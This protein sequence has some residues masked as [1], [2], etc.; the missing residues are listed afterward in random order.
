VPLAGCIFLVIRPFH[1]FIYLF[2]LEAFLPLHNVHHLFYFFDVFSG[3]G[4][5]GGKVM[6]SCHA[7]AGRG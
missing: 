1:Y 7:A 3:S 2:P 5:V 6:H 4:E